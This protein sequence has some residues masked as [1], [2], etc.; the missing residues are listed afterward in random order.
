MLFVQRQETDS[1]TQRQYYKARTPGSSQ[2]SSARNSED[3]GAPARSV[4][5]TNG[6]ASPPPPLTR[7]QTFTVAPAQPLAPIQPPPAPQYTSNDYLAPPSPSFQP[8]PP[9]QMS[10]QAAPAAPADAPSDVGAGE[11][12]REVNA[13]SPWPERFMAFAQQ[14][15][16]KDPG[17]T[18]LLLD[19][20]DIDP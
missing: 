5:T 15:Y 12:R 18:G 10:Y 6:F 20:F 16:A 7:G 8:Q 1:K 13:S 17:H 14:L 3:G 19:L 4:T 2:Q 11:S 9:P